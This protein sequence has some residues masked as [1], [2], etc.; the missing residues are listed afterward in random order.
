VTIVDS[1][2]SQGAG[3]L[4]VHENGCDDF[5]GVLGW[6]SVEGWNNENVTVELSSPAAD[7]GENADLCAMLHTDDGNGEYDF[8]AGADEPSDVPVANSED[9]VVMSTFNVSVTEGTP[10]IRITLGAQGNNAYTVDSVEPGR[11]EGDT[12]TEDD[13]PTFELR[14]NWRYEF[15]NTVTGNHPFEFITGASD[16]VHLS[17]ESDPALEDDSSINW[18]EDGSTFRFTVGTG[19]GPIDTYRCEQHPDS[20]RGPVST[21]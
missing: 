17:Q 5:G 2:V 1:V 15:E 16:T 18:W 10:A 9:E 12:G 6:A 4:V 3:W 14:T 11:F 7:G 13:D 19:F 8:D 21:P 20:M